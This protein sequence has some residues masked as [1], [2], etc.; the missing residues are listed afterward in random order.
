MKEPISHSHFAGQHKRDRPSEQAKQQENTSTR[1]KHRTHPQE[2]HDRGQAT[3][4]R[5]REPKE[6]LGTM[7]KKDKRGNYAQ[8]S[9]SVWR[10]TLELVQGQH[11][12]PPGNLADRTPEQQQGF[13]ISSIRFSALRARNSL[14]AKLR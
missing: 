4:W 14:L 12:E 1:L 11:G 2:W 8:Q 9:Q 10:P 13:Y 6:L 5:R 7:L 3:L